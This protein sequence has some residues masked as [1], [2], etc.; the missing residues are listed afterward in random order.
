MTGVPALLL[1]H[2]VV[3]WLTRRQW[4]LAAAVVVSTLAFAAVGCLAAQTVLMWM[5]NRLPEGFWA[6]YLQTLRSALSLDDINGPI[7][8]AKASTSGFSEIF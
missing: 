6:E 4:P 3:E 8:Q 7:F 1:G 5:G 2:R